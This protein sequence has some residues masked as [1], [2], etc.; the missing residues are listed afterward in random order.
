MNDREFCPAS[1]APGWNMY[2]FRDGRRPVSGPD[3]R[4]ELAN[5]L[6]AIPA[7]ADAR[8]NELTEALIRA[9]ELECALADAQHPSEHQLGLI[10]DALAA[11]FVGDPAAPAPVASIAHLPSALPQTLH[12]S[13]PEGFAYYALHPRDVAVLASE[14]PSRSQHLLVIGIRTIGVTLS[15]VVAA[16]LRKRGKHARR[17]NVRPHGHPYDRCTT[18]SDEQQSFICQY[19]NANAD[20]LIVDEGPGMSGSSFLSVADALVAARVPR[21]RI[22]LLCSREPDVSQLRARDAQQRWAQYR[23]MHL[24]PNSL[25]PRDAKV[26]IGAGLWRAE[27][28]P[29]GAEWPESW[30]HMERLKFL[31]PD[32]RTLFK[33][34]GLGPYGRAVHERVRR[35]QQAGFGPQC[36]SP[37]YG[38]GIYPLETGR[39]L[40]ADDLS[41]KLITRIARYCAM[42]AHEFRVRDGHAPAAME[43][44]TRFNF[45]QEFGE[46]APS[47]LESPDGALAAVAPV[48]A[49]ARMQ[50]HEWLL[51]DDERVLKL[52][53]AEHGDD[54]FFPGPT[55]IA[56]DLAGAVVEWRM[57]LDAQQ[58]L[59]REYRRASGDN[60]GPRIRPFLLAYSSFRMGYCKMAAEAVMGSGEEHRLLAAYRR[61]RECLARLTRRDRAIAGVAISDPS[62]ANSR[63]DSRGSVLDGPSPEPLAA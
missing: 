4:S 44:M 38:F 60:A 22:T 35:L 29:A 63:D 8:N 43:Q 21:D 9:G 53:G 16:E 19:R 26:Y 56:W 41:R 6:G 54:H 17:I 39:L 20:F 46:S 18:F 34:E 48:V 52:D 23:T 13:P 32:K 14:A 24:Q 10:T 37:E 57:N 25:L 33:F 61:Y 42:R 45:Q 40:R 30:L 11:S 15:A 28:L 2:V 12:V 31:S 1:G 50:P 62:A 59:L 47:P 49:D 55:D 51:I 27:F 5:L 36:E 58:T 7:S 3:L